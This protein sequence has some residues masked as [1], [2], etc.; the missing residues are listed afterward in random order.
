MVGKRPLAR[1]NTVGAQG[2]AAPVPFQRGEPS[3]LLNGPR[4]SARLLQRPLGGACFGVRGWRSVA[5]D[6]PEPA[7]IQGHNI[8]R[9]FR[10]MWMQLGLYYP[11]SIQ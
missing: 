10:W 7:V 2:A 11:R 9:A 4:C 3:T 1:T 6:G 5:A 8:F